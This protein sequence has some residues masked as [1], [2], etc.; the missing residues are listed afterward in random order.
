VAAYE[1]A[2]KHRGGGAS[3]YRGGS[4]DKR[5]RALRRTTTPT[6]IRILAKHSYEFSTLGPGAISQCRGVERPKRMEK[7]ES[8]QGDGAAG[9]VGRQDHVDLRRRHTLGAIEECRGIFFSG[10]PRH[11][12]DFGPSHH[13][14]AIPTASGAASAA[15]ELPRIV[16][17]WEEGGGRAGFYGS[18][19]GSAI[20]GTECPAKG[21]IFRLG[22]STSMPSDRADP[23]Q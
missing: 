3:P 23:M 9:E 5:V 12:E 18:N 4:G 7:L 17:T 6:D 20:T 19:R 1:A 14:A 11:V 21:L 16:T 2:T 22:E 10:F 15:A 8:L 13:F